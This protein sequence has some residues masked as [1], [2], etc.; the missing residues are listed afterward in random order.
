MYDGASYG[1]CRGVRAC[2]GYRYR[3][4]RNSS[5]SRLEAA[6]TGKPE[7]QLESWMED[8]FRRVG[9]RQT[10]GSVMQELRANLG[11]VERATDEY[12]RDPT[13][14]AALIPVPVAFE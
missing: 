9:D 10:L 12:F 8:L 6:A 1:Y 5:A 3:R 13:R 7:E 4:C 2:G 14:R 11:E